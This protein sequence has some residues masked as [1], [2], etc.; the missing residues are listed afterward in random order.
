MIAATRQS[1]STDIAK[2]RRDLAARYETHGRQQAVLQ[3]HLDAILAIAQGHGV[4]DDLADLI[5]RIADA[6]AG[7]DVNFAVETQFLCAVEVALRGILG[8]VR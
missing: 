3:H 5:G 6:R 2:M 4:E 7:M 8:R 1:G